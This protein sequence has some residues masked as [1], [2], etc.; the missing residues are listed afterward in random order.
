MNPLE[1]Q[2]LQITQQLNPIAANHGIESA[3]VKQHLD[4]LCNRHNN[5]FLFISNLETLTPLYICNE[6][7]LFLGIHKTALINPKPGYFLN[8]I[9]RENLNLIHQNTDNF[10][11]KKNAVFKEVIKVKSASGEWHWVYVVSQFIPAAD[12][13]SCHIISLGTNIE[14]L[15][16]MNDTILPSFK[17]ET[18]ERE[19]KQNEHLTKLSTREKEILHLILNEH[20]DTQIAQSLHISHHTVRTHRKTVM[21]KLNVKSAMGLARVA[22]ESELFEKD[23]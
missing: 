20:S 16:R 21:R 8:F 1:R 9:H 10:L 15:L 4:L 6:G 5:R 11:K 23:N 19:K 17:T 3:A 22:M 7:L 18:H 14:D 12:N 2:L 13:H